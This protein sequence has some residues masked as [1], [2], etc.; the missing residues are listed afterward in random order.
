[1][2]KDAS[3]LYVGFYKRWG[4]DLQVLEFE[5]E[6]D[7]ESLCLDKHFNSR[8][9]IIE[10]TFSPGKVNVYMDEVEIQWV[11]EIKKISVFQ[12]NIIIF[13]DEAS[14]WEYEKS[15]KQLQYKHREQWKLENRK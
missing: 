8:P 7:A 14:K 3:E 9:Y 12:V 11:W 4:D 13:A 2:I 10:T 5:A 6:C 1:M 15:T